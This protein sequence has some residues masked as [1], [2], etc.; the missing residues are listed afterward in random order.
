MSFATMRS[1]VLTDQ[2][3]LRVFEEVVGFGG[4]ADERLMGFLF[5]E[6]LCD[7]RILFK[8]ERQCIV[9]FF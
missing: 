8:W 7:V 5:A 9:R 3:L 2:F 4:E 6:S 1:Q